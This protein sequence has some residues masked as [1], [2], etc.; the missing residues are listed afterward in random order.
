MTESEDRIQ[1]A[2][3]AHLEHAEIGGPGPDV[4]HLTDAELE[5]LRELIALLD[6]TEGVAFGRGL[7]EVRYDTA[8]A[9]SDA[10]AK[11]VA[12]MRNS[13][14]ASARIANDP[15]ATTIAVP[16]M[17]VVDGW[18]VGTFGGRIRVWLLADSSPLDASEQWLRDLD[19]VFK[20]FP[21][22]A[23]LTLVEADLSCLLVQPEDC[24]PTIEVPR[25]SL[26]GRRYR[27]PVHPVGEALSVFFRELIPH[28]E[29]MLGIGDESVGAIDVTAIARERATRAVDDQAA[30][31][32]RARKTNPK[33]KALTELGAEEAEAVARS[34]LDVHDGRF[35]P[36]AVAEELRRIASKP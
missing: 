32:A 6:S 12:E 33:R 15:A 23:A 11:L 27:R 4:S 18:V 7:D 21:D 20:T 31:G 29:P 19:R 1:R 5:Q 24:A 26:V 36:D 25:G 16:G 35:E 13:L 3:A 14:P 8:T 28:W 2:L 30:A 17:T 34:V 10:G 9:S 22:T